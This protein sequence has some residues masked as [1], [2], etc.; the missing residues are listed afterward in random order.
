M[1]TVRD[2]RPHDPI[3]DCRVQTESRTVAHWT[4]AHRTVANQGNEKADNCSLCVNV[5]WCT[6]NE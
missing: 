5:I 2:I 6:K 1:R 3:N 4:V